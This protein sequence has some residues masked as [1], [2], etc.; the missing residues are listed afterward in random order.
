MDLNRPVDY[1]AR[2]AEQYSAL[3]FEPYQ[4]A[5]RPAAPPWAPL[6]KPLSES[7]ILLVGSG[8]AYREGQVAFHWKDDTGIRHI[9][10][11]QPASDVRVTHF[12]YDLEP[13]R[14]DPNIVF[15]VDRLNEMVT[16]GTIGGLAPEALACMGGIYSV[17]R[18]EEELAPAILDA[19]EQMPT[20]IDLVLLVPV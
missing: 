8:G 17:R 10:T 11:D 3:G 4:W 18:A 12:A 5:H 20:D 9:P 14:S 7:T 19:V 13:A 16:D 6:D 15:P 2:T 1:I